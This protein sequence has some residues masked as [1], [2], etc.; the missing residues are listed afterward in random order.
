[1]NFPTGLKQSNKYLLF[2]FTEHVVD[3]QSHLHHIRTI[4]E[5]RCYYL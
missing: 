3:L 1:M 4:L 2:T 5:L